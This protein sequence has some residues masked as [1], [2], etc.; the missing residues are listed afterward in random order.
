M[1]K[2]S[3][4]ALSAIAVAAIV[5]FAQ[6]ALA[7]KA[8]ADD[9]ALCDFIGRFK[10]VISTLRTL[11]FI[12]A[13]FVIMEWAWG[14]ISKGDVGKDDLKNKGVALLVGFALLLGVGFFL[15]FITSAAGQSAM[16]CVVKAFD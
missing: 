3:K 10:G 13:A 16:G 1:K 6:D 2:I 12:G 8:T 5:V 11:A 7:A 9:T 15:N 4:Y 14:F